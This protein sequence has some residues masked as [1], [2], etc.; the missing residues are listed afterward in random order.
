MTNTQVQELKALSIEDI[1]SIHDAL[2]AK[3]RATQKLIHEHIEPNREKYPSLYRS[4]QRQL[5]TESDRLVRFNK[6]LSML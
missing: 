3:V 4:Y 6:I 2:D 1:E 5:L